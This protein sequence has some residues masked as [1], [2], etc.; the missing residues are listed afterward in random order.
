MLLLTH[1]WAKFYK[2]KT[3]KFV[4]RGLSQQIFAHVLKVT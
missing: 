2:Q 3:K 1:L 4:R